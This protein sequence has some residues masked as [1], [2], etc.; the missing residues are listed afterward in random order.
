MTEK[1]IQVKALSIVDTLRKERLSISSLQLDTQHSNGEFYYLSD[2]LK[3][4]WRKDWEDKY[5]G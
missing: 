1:E 5:S 3:I 2:N 4:G